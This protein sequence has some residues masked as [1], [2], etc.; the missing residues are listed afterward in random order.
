MTKIFMILCG[1]GVAIALYSGEPAPKL[2]QHALDVLGQCENASADRSKGAD[3]KTPCRA[4]VAAM[5]AGPCRAY[6]QGMLDA[7]PRGMA[8]FSR[9]LALAQP[10]S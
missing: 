10:T 8:D 7:D 5:P 3:Y 4:A 9:C 6:A 1:L 2:S